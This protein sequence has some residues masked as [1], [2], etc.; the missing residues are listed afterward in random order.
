MGVVLASDLLGMV[1]VLLLATLTAWMAADR[2]QSPLPWFFL[3]LFFPLIAILVL[4]VAFPDAA[5]TQPPT[6]ADALGSSPVARTLGGM[7]GLSAH[8]LTEQTHLPEAEVLE[9]LAA[10]RNLGQAQRDETGRWTL[11]AS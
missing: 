7:P 10:L 3:G 1:I 4:L 9:H 5:G 11:S 8:Q 6:V 2:G